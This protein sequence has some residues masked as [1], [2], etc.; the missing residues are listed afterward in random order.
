VAPPALSA[1]TRENSLISAP[2][3]K[4]PEAPVNTTSLTSRCG[5]KSRKAAARSRQARRS[6]ALRRAGRSIVTSATEGAGRVTRI[7]VSVKSAVL[8]IHFLK[9]V[10]AL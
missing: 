2:A 6:S 9:S 1:R 10:G 3:Q 8:S 4:W 5:A 7:S